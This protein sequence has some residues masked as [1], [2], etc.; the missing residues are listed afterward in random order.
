MPGLDGLR[1]IAVLAVIAYHLNLDWASGGLLGVAV[2]FTLSGYLITDLLLERWAG[3]RLSLGEFWLARARRLLPALF[4]MLV[5]VFAWVT[6]GDPEQLD[7]LRGEAIASAFFISN[8]WFIFQDVSYFEQFGPPSPLGHLWS[9][10]V[11]EQ[12][13]IVGFAASARIAGPACSRAWRSRPSCSP[14]SRSA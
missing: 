14:R 8:W 6:I 7:R 13:Y 4:V 10:G 2:F 12:F 9:L 3:R 1:A 11:E 5:V